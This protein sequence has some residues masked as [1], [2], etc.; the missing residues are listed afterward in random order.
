VPASF[1]VITPSYAQGPFIERTIKSVLAQN[2]PELDFFVVDGGS[3][4]ETVPILQR[5]CNQLRFV[6]EPDRGQTD[7]VNKGLIGTDA[8]LIGW[9]N[10]DD[11]YYPDALAT[12]IAY[13]EAHPEVDVVYGRGQHIDVRDQ[14]IE[15]YPTEDWNLTRLSETCFICQPAVFFRRRVI[16]RYGLLNEN[17]RF[18]MDYEYW[19]RLGRQGAVFAYLSKVLAGSRFYP[20]TKTLGQRLAVH[21]EIN[22]MLKGHFGRVPSRWLANY[23]H[24][25]A[26]QAGITANDRSR[27]LANLIWRTLRASVRWRALPDA[28][29]CRLLG[30]WSLE[31]AGLGSLSRF[32]RRRA[33]W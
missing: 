22:D 32:I 31:L 20:G 15:D 29:L 23:G 17:L 24:V 25:E 6:S 27:F 19:L 28:Q 8:P 4:D 3:K 18:C 16:E 14:V 11:V 13:F 26:E 5:Y 21:A 7:A 10:S 30:S 12:V 33:S 2:V 9:L 1:C